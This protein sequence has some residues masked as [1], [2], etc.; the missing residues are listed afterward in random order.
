MGTTQSPH[1][2]SFPDSDSR[3]GPRPN[4][5]VVF[6]L[7]SPTLAGISLLPKPN[8]ANVSTAPHSTKS[9]LDQEKKSIVSEAGSQQSSVKSPN[10][11]TSR[12]SR[13]ESLAFPKSYEELAVPYPP[14]RTLQDVYTRGR[15][16]GSGTFAD[17]YEAIHNESGKVYALK[18]IRKGK[19]HGREKVVHREIQILKLLAVHPHVVGMLPED[20]FFESDDSFHIIMEL[21]TGGELFDAIVSRGYFCERDAVR[22]VAQV[23]DAIAYCH[24]HGVVHRDLKPEVWHFIEAARLAT[25]LF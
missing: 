25:C 8:K 2:N 6:N 13:P 5:P 23:L 16:L 21:C 22:I 12:P 15:R 11:R 10:R 3:L 14:T 9:P 7:E 17:V 18:T 24:S 1:L 19:L 20:G 4:G